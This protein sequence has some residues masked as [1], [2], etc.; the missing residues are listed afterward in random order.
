MPAAR[1]V[2]LLIAALTFA[3]P[4]SACKDKAAGDTG[5][6]EEGEAAFAVSPPEGGA[7]TSMTVL[8]EASRSSFV[9][10]E[11]A[12]D[13]G[14]GVTVDA[15]T[16]EDGWTAVAEITIAADAETGLRDVAVD[17]EGRVTTLPEAFRVREDSFSITPDAGKM[18]ETVEVT[19]VGVNTRWE[20]GRTWIN[21]GDDIE[22]V[23]FTVLSETIA[24][25]TVAIAADAAPGWRD[26]WTEDGAHVVTLYD[27]F[28][29]DRVAIA[30][31]WDP[32]TVEQGDTVEFTLIGRDT[33][34]TDAT[35]LRFY[36]GDYELE[37]IVVQD[38]TV[39]DAENLWGRVA[40][41]NAAE[42]GWR[43]V[44]VTTGDEGVMLRDAF[45]VTPGG[46]ALDEVAVSLSFNV[47]RG[48]DNSTGEIQE[49]VNS[50]CI[51]FI[52]LDPPCPDSAEAAACTDGV[53]NDYDGYTDCY[54][55]DCETN[56]AC[57][58]Q[59]PMP[60]DSNLVVELRNTGGD[61][62]D[63]PSPQTVS[64]GDYV[65]LESPA[66]TVTLVK[67]IDP[68]SGA[69]YYAPESAL[70]MDDYVTGQWY[71]LHL[72]GDPEALPEE[73]I[74]RVQPTV[75]ADFE[76]LTPQLWNNY[77]HDR[78]EDFVYT[79]T[80]A[81]TY[82]D[83]ILAASIGGTTL[84]SNGE[85]ASLSTYPWDD[86]EWQFT[87]SELLQLNPNNVSFDLYSYIEGVQF[88]LRDSIYQTNETE[89]YIYLSG[90]LIL[91]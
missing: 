25:A 48:I 89:S 61:P 76:L 57:A 72:Q 74:E 81:Q 53:D 69:I 80:P 85:P 65:W 30:A 16:V 15:L 87:S 43:D 9:F 38:I 41:S 78:N 18:G 62:H 49:S 33:N 71:D 45:E 67:N 23:S 55:T 2:W 5:A 86:G 84:V 83:A 42:L 73:I 11:T 32:E 64:A 24:E 44:L 59:G 19:V 22:V 50:Q 63:C 40:V 79:W 60:Y 88:G 7:G 14:E 39:L 31:T 1:F 75:P 90:S 34:F 52:P 10:G 3:L 82:P 20:A 58:P 13:F 27:G 6:A 54:D 37:D 51:F 29:V 66:N 17:I 77:T 21:F 35:G 70:S 36:D 91:E 68:G 12:L 47:V 28:L 8:V 56:M 26:V 4:L 46:V